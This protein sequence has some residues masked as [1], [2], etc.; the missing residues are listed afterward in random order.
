MVKTEF[1]V[2]PDLF[3]LADWRLYIANVARSYDFA[4]FIYLEKLVKNRK[5]Y[6]RIIRDK[7]IYLCSLLK[8]Y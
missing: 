3:S 6:L 7:D 2:R 5:Y 1:W 8:L 4:Y